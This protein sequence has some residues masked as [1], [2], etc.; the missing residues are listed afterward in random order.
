MAASTIK[1]ITIEIGGD[2]TKLDKALSGVNKQSRDLQK[3]LKEVEKGLKLDP[4]NTE[5]LA[6]KQTL[7]KE[8]VAAT[9]EKLDVLKSA[10]AQAQKQFENGEV[11]EEQYR[12][13]QR[14][15]I[16]TEADLKNLKTAAEDSNST[17]EKAGEIAGKIGKKSEAL[18]KKLLPVTGAIAGIGT[19]S[20]A[21]FNEL[22]AGYDTNENGRFRGSVGR[23]TRQY[24]RRFYFASNRSGNGRNCD[25]RGK[26][27]LRFYRKRT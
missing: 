20:I 11:S 4:K 5:L 6:Q 26:H 24:G 18:G 10:E 23:L 21:A 3:E 22:D 12:A 14:E 17:L 2:T 19:A 16:K 9:S 27:P 25:R 7:L 13:L 8:A 15:I 1:G